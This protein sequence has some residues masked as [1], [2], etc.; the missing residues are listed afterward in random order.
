MRLPPIGLFI[1]LSMTLLSGCAEHD[2]PAVFPAHLQV[3]TQ[4]REHIALR[5]AGDPGQAFHATLIVDG[6]TQEISGVSPAE[7]PFE[8]C[9]L[10]GRIQKLKGEGSLT[11]EIRRPNG[12]MN[13]FGNLVHPGSRFRFAYH[14]GGVEAQGWN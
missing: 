2:E 1:A 5:T 11:F 8:V 7:Y 12:A 4:A 3:H 6:Q 9:L 10:T 13:G 14:D